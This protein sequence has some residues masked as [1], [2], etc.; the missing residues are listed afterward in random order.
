MSLLVSETIAAATIITDRIAVIDAV[1]SHAPASSS[2]PLYRAGLP[3][4][5]P[6]VP[7][8][9]RADGQASG[10]GSRMTS[11]SRRLTQNRCNRSNP[12]KVAAQRMNTSS[13]HARINRRQVAVPG[14]RLLA[15][16]E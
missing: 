7:R 3:P 15:A 4:W 5:P 8:K 16:Q 10:S 9:A 11:A 2:R 6:P 1:R 12:A 13:V 14:F